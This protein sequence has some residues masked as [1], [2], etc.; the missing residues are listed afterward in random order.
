[1]ENISIDKYIE[2][3]EST[4]PKIMRSI[5]FTTLKDLFGLGLDITLSQF[6]VLVT[7]FHD[8]GCKMNS[9]ANKLSLSPGAMTG[10]VDRLEK[11]ELVE[12]MYDL[13]DRR[14]VTVWLS[15][16]GKKFVSEFQK[17]K[18]E[19]LK[20]V[21]NKI[22]EQNKEKLIQS[23]RAFDQALTEILH[24]AGVQAEGK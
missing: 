7:I 8:T 20:A 19:Y 13:R 14:V 2:E 21:L 23:L 22:G 15:E 9:L 1:M 5:Q 17:K 18:T 12:R 10:L 3:I 4:I 6:Y 24:D 16:A 11:Q